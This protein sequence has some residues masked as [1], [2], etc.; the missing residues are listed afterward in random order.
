MQDCHSYLLYFVLPTG[1]F[2]QFKRYLM[3]ISICKYIVHYLA[4]FFLEKIITSNFSLRLPLPLPLSLWIY[5]HP[6]LFMSLCVYMHIH[7]SFMEKS[8]DTLCESVLFFHY[9]PTVLGTE[10][11]SLGLVTGDFTHGSM[12]W[13]FSF[14]KTIY[15]GE[16][17]I[18]HT[19]VVYLYLCIYW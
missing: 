8:E 19:A 10:L 13:P 6:Y 7:I 3:L 18:W 17:F 14:L 16:S 12:I 15:F 9:V 2:D 4:V 1:K 11:R 5:A